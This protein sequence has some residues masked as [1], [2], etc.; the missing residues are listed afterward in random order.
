PFIIEK[1]TASGY[2]YFFYFTAAQKVGVAVADHPA[3]PFTD[4][5]KP[6]VDKLPRGVK[7]GQQIDPEVF[8]DPETGKNY[9]YWGNGYMAAAELNDDMVS[10]KE[11]TISVM[12]PDKT[13]RE[14]STVFYRNGK[15]Y[16]MWS[17]DDTRSV[18][19]K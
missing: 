17:E 7:G 14:G 12:T 16:F 10:I 11:E 6:L 1:K 2:K 4:S 18:N 19:Y 15:Y 5:G 8:S 13:Y 9:L 3:G